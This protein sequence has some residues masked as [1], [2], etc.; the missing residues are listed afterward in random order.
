[1]EGK[2]CNMG[3]GPCPNDER[4]NLECYNRYG[5][6]GFC[7]KIAGTFQKLCLCVYRCI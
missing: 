1:V 6:T 2:N 7:N 3:W 5:G 4:C